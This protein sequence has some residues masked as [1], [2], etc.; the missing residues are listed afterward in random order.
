MNKK[1]MIIIGVI[2]VVALCG[3]AVLYAPSLIKMISS[4][5]TVPQH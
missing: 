5:H 3:L 4:L 1:V 2:I